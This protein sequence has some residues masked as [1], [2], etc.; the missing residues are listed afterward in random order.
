MEISCVN[1]AIYY[2][3]Y[4]DIFLK[5]LLFL[6]IYTNIYIYNV[7]HCYQTKFNIYFFNVL[8]NTICIRYLIMYF[9]F[10]VFHW[11][12]LIEFVLQEKMKCQLFEQF[13]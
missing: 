1:L 5:S 13:V 3:V 2:A 10:G 9:E 6:S 12:N 11:I 7:F 4:L 8:N